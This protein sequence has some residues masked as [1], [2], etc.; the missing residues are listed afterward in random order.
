MKKVELKELLKGCKLIKDSNGEIIVQTIAN[1][2]L[3]CLTAAN[4][5]SI[6]TFANPM[7]VL[8]SNRS[9]GHLQLH[10]RTAKDMIVPPQIAVMTKKAAQ[11]HGMVKGAFVKANSTKDF[12]DAGCV[13]G[14]QTGYLDTSDNDIRFIPFGAREYIFEKVGVTGSHTNIYDAIEKVGNDTH[15]N[16]GK[17]L[18]QYF[19]K[20]DK[21]LNEFIA[22]FERPEKCIG[23]IVLIDGEIV[24]IDKFPSFEYCE[25][26]WDALIR[27]CYGSIAITQEVKGK[28]GSKSFTSMKNRLKKGADESPAAFLK[29]ALSKTKESIVNNVKEKLSDMLEMELNATVDKDSTGNGYESDIIKTEGYIGQVISQSSYRHLV[30]IVKKDSFKPE[31]FREAIKLKKLA[32]D[33]DEFSL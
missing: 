17:Y 21:K 14:S 18:D 12:N 19:S 26:I 8:G 2:Q 11:N 30:S 27:D 23:T 10:N 6:N 3:V 25:Q 5:F 29:R 28:T 33:Q 24:A 20:Y 22:H 32:K 1:M 16:S 31:K 13:Q 7:T 15:A 9:Y 4:E